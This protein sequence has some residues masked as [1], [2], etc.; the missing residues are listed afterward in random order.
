MRS[1]PSINWSKFHIESKDLIAN[2]RR[3][4][5]K[6]IEIPPNIKAQDNSNSVMMVLNSPRIRSFTFHKQVSASSSTSTP[7]SFF[8]TPSTKTQSTI[9]QPYTHAMSETDSSSPCNDSI[10]SGETKIMGERKERKLTISPCPRNEFF[11]ALSYLKTVALGCS[12]PVATPLKTFSFKQ[13]IPKTDSLTIIRQMRTIEK[14]RVEETKIRITK[15]SWDTKPK[16][17]DKRTKKK[18]RKSTVPGNCTFRLAL[19]KLSLEPLYN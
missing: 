12:S 6:H 3:S 4:L 9:I 5:L 19:E 10:D 8:P 1:I 13:E 16:V 15:A 2:V 18:P 17:K 14:R 11:S 7:R